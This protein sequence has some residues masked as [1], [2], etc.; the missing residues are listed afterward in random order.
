MRI[1]TEKEIS[2][3][4]HLILG[5]EDRDEL[6]A[7]IDYLIDLSNRQVKARGIYFLSIL[8]NKLAEMGN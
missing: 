8:Y 3:I 6:C 5:E 2:H 4:I 1:E 7:E